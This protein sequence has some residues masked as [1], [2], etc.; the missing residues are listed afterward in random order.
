[1][2][3]YMIMLILGRDLMIFNTLFGEFPPDAWCREHR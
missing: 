3:L 1:V 2:G